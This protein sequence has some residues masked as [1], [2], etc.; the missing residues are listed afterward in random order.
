MG[1]VPEDDTVLYLNNRILQ[2]QIDFQLKRD[3]FLRKCLVCYST[4]RSGFICPEPSCPQHAWC[5]DYNDFEKEN[6]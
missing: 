4:W 5:I 6:T 1:K 3:T 2:A